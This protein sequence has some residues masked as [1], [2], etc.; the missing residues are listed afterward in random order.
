M[1]NVS[2]QFTVRDR[3]TARLN[4][5][6]N[7]TDRLNRSLDATDA[8][9]NTV[10]PGSPFERSAQAVDRAAGAVDNFNERQDRADR[11]AKNIASSWGRLKGVIHG[12]LAA[13]SAKK[14][15]ELSDSMITTTAR[16]D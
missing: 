6:T 11:G 15:M 9:T 10:D 3:M 5:M 14:I 12:A 7:A 16:L 13:F 8:A 1:A 2:T 4:A